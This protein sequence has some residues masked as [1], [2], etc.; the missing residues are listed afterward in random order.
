MDWVID[1]MREM[2]EKEEP[3]STAVFLDQETR[4]V[5]Y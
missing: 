5:I 3:R 2:R 4:I 1:L